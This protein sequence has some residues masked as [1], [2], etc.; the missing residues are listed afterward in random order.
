MTETLGFVVA[1]TQQEIDI[2]KQEAAALLQCHRPRGASLQEIPGLRQ[3]PWVAQHAAAHEHA[4]HPIAHAAD[5]LLRLDAI[6]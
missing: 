6:T 4:A 1:L 3:N 2:F 5:D